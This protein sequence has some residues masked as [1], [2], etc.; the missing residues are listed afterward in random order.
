MEFFIYIIFFIIGLLIGSFATLA[1]YRIPIGEN[2]THKRSFCPSCNHKLGFLDLIPVLSY[3]FLKGKCRY[4]SQKIGKRYIFIEI[5]SGI[6][7]LSFALSLNI[8][9]YAIEASKFI[10]LIFGFLYFIALLLIAGMDKEKRFISKKVILY[11][12]I[13][14]FAYILYLYIV[15]KNNMYRYAIYLFFMSFFLLMNTLLLQ[16]KGKGNYTIDILILCMLIITFSGTIVFELT[17][18]LTL[19]FI[20]LSTIVNAMKKR[21]EKLSIGF[22][23]CI[24]NILILILQNFIILGGD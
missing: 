13:V 20:L 19:L 7:F 3:V 11:G 15:G 22:Y 5:C 21:E 24:S 6:I 10:Y 12:V 16:K 14:N 17:V 9:F 23:L 4:C 8:D 2:I 18:I 1:I